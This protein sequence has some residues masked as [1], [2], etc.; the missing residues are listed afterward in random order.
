MD[1]FK[2]MVRL[3]AGT[4]ATLETLTEGTSLLYDRARF[5][6]SNVYELS[7]GDTSVRFVGCPDQPAL[8]N[9]AVLT[10]GPR[11]VALHVVANDV[12]TTTSITAYG[13]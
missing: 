3:T 13:S 4:E 5:K 10:T 12:D 11:S 8:F 2:V 1:T 9:G 6:E 7:D